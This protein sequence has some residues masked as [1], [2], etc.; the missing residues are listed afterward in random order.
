MK[1]KKL[2][3][4]VSYL[5]SVVLVLTALTFSPL[6]AGAD[7]TLD[8]LKQAQAELEQKISQNKSKMN[9]LRQ[10]INNQEAYLSS[11]YEDISY[12]SKQLENLQDQIDI[13]N[14]KIKDVE[15]S[16]ATLEKE[17]KNIDVDIEQNKK[18]IKTNEENVKNSYSALASRLKSAYITG[19]STDLKILLG[20]DDIATFLT[21]L[22]LMK[23]VSENDANLI[24]TFKA[25]I[26]V[27]KASQDTLKN[28]TEVLEAKQEQIAK[29]NEDLYTSRAE[30]LQTKT[31]LSATM[32]ELE[33]KYNDVESYISQLDRNSKAYQNLISKQEA[34]EAAAE[35]EINAYINAHASKTPQ[36]GSSSPVSSGTYMLP[37]K[38]SGIY[39]SSPFG[40]RYIFGQNGTHGGVDLCA[41]NIYGQSIYASRS[42][43][44]IY[45]DPYEKTTYGKYII[46]DHGDGYVTLYAHCSKLLVSSGQYVNQGDVIAKVGDTGRVSGPHLHFEVRKDNVRQNPLNY[47]KV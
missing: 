28:R 46:I 27:L 10:E 1:S 9:S 37:L 2:K 23:R 43:T 26:E 3:R 16:I 17:I 12:T 39:V 45:T 38:C 24:R 20:S 8:Q 19:Q 4:L 29:S 18:E 41:P 14:Q 36:G 33:K 7:S 34:E 47:I 22:E 11:V 32:G 42:G 21:R 6:Q 30:L 40:P 25:E 31:K 5:L 44:V 15:D 13:Y 35:R